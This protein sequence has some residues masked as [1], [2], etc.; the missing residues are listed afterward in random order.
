MLDSIGRNDH[1]LGW[2]FQNLMFIFS[3]LLKPLYHPEPT[4]KNTYY[5]IKAYIKKEKR[6]R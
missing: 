3:V 1:Q 2:P 4:F 5:T 6:H